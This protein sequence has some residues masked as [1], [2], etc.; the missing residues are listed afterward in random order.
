MAGSVSLLLADVRLLPAAGSG[1][2]QSPR[3]TAL[4]SRET[5]SR[6]HLYLGLSSLPSVARDRPANTSFFRLPEEALVNL[7]WR[8]AIV[9]RATPLPAA[10]PIDSRLRGDARPQP[11]QVTTQ[12]LLFAL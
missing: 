10:R 3:R 5:F 12:L 9:S 1:P 7:Y 8:V 4:L 11:V 2:G 6:H